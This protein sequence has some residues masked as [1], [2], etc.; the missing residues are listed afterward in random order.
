MIQPEPEGST[1]GYPLYSV[2]VLSHGPSDAMHKP[3]PANQSQK[4]FVSKLTEIHSF[5]STFSLRSD[6][7]V[8]TMPM[9]ILLE[10]TSNKLLVEHAEYDESNTYMLERFNTTAGNSVK[11]ILLKLNLPDHRSILTDSKTFE[12]QDLSN[13]SH[14]VNVVK[15]DYKPCLVMVFANVKAKRKKCGIERNYVL[16]SVKERKKRLDMSMDSPFGQQATT[17]LAPP[18]TISRSVSGDFIAPPKFLKDVFGEPKMR[19][20]NADWAMVSPHF[21]TCTL[22]GLTIDYYSNGVM[23][24]VAWRDVENVYFPVN[25]PKKHWCLAELHISTEVV[26]FYDSLGWS[27][28]IA[29]ETYEIKY[30]FPKVVRLSCNLPLTVDDPLQTALAYCERILQ[31]FWRHKIQAE[32]TIVLDEADSGDSYKHYLLVSFDMINHRFQVID[33]P[34]VVMRGLSVLLYVSNLRNSLVLSGNIRI[35]EYYV[36]VC[37]QL[38]SDGGSITS[39]S[40][41]QLLATLWLTRYKCTWEIHTHL[42]MQL[43]KAMLGGGL[44]SYVDLVMVFRHGL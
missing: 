36:F 26:T 39:A 37:C 6:T 38:S 23:Y 14:Y 11:E 21:L 4:D 29:V 28:G 34:D 3:F 25:E 41:K 13:K 5:L 24:P 43:S 1:Q 12:Y 8:F 30:M 7:Y 2:E 32:K 40:L 27:K 22:G 10:P 16:R 31:Y 18:K 17:T 15:E 44:I 42:R 20:P 9:E 33:I 35:P 19:E